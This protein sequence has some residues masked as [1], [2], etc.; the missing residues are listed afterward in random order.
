M[1]GGVKNSWIFGKYDGFCYSEVEKWQI[2]IPIPFGGKP[3]PGDHR[4]SRMNALVNWSCDFVGVGEHNVGGVSTQPINQS[5]SSVNQPTPRTSHFSSLWVKYIRQ[6]HKHLDRSY[7]KRHTDQYQSI[8]GVRNAHIRHGTFY[9][10]VLMGITIIW[11]FIG[12][13]RTF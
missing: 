11:S 8:Y 1:D 3:S 4:C 9:N 10:C 13:Y 7:L 6:N 5:I 12:L 2:P